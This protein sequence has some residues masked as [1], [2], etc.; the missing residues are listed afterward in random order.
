MHTFTKRNSR[1]ASLRIIGLFA[2]AAANLAAQRGAQ[3]PPIVKENATVKISDHVYVIPDDSVPIVP[4][5]GIIV[6]TKATLVVD[7][8]LGTRN[9]ETVLREVAKVSKNPDLYLVA[10]HFHPEH[11]GGALAFPVSAK[12]VVSA[13]QQK[14]LDELGP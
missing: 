14:D 1:L 3:P 5:V 6:G 10:T 2:I 12:F 4:N 7:T 11:A 8:G 13:M 9:G